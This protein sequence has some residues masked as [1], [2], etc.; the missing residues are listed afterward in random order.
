MSDVRKMVLMEEAE[1]DRMRQKQL[2]EY[3]PTLSAMGRAQ[4]QIQEALT[5]DKLTDEEKLALLTEVQQRFSR[6]KSSIG[7]IPKAEPPPTLEIATPDVSNKKRAAEAT[8]DVT[9]FQKFLAQYPKVLRASDKDELVFRN[10]AIPNTSYSQLIESA[11]TDTDLTLP[12]MNKFIKALR[13]I[14]APANVLKSEEFAKQVYPSL[15]TA[16]PESKPPPLA[17]SSFA[18]SSLSTTKLRTHSKKGQ[19]G[20]GHPPPGQRPRLVFLYH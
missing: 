15:E 6:L 2:K 19:K 9:E 14:H 7:V 5:D 4:S 16:L 11:V 18:N 12:G 20:K 3:D 1:L 10:R 8:K 17:S 13:T